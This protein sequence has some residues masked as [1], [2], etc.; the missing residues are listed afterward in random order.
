MGYICH[1]AIVVTGSADHVERAWHHAHAMLSDLQDGF[2]PLPMGML[3][4]LGETVVNGTK[5]FSIWPDGSKEGWSTS[6]E[7]DAFR[8]DF[9]DYLD[10]AH[11]LYVAWCEVRFGDEA[12][13][14]GMLRCSGEPPRDVTHF[15]RSQDQAT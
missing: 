9:I 11:D 8:Q 10:G 1:N 7:G 5:S 12:D 13:M 4:P 15:G 2:D 6:D 14:N 3:S